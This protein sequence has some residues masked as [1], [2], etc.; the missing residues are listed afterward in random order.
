M[1]IDCLRVLHVLPTVDDA[2]GG[3]PRVV[4]AFL[5]AGA[6]LGIRSQVIA[7]ATSGDGDVARQLAASS[8]LHT[9][10]PG[11]V[12]GRLYG[13]AAMLRAVW[14]AV[15]EA[16]VVIAHSLFCLPSVFSWLICRLRRKPWVMS[17]HGC[18]DPYDVL[19]HSGLKRLLTP[20]WRGLLHGADVW[21]MTDVEAR[22]L[23][24]FGARPRVHV[25]PP[26][27]DLA[28]RL[29]LDDA[30]ALLDGGGLNLRGVVRAGGCVVSF[31][32][33]FDVKKG[34]PRLLDC[35]DRVARDND[36]LVLAGRGG[37]SYE[38]VVDGHLD[39]AE[40]R[41]QILR[42]GWLSDE[43]KV[44]LWSLPGFFALAGDNENF[45]VAVA[46]AMA[47]GM[48]V[49]VTDQV[50]LADLVTLSGA[51]LVSAPETRRFAAAM[52]VYLTDGERRRRDGERGRA[53]VQESMS[54]EACQ[55]AF[56]QMLETAISEHRPVRRLASRGA[57]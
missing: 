20:L 54:V 56:R 7:G 45:G 39:R 46:E 49:V 18:L 35:F 17:P 9:F 41:G 21:C 36:V 12:F 40:R 33:R 37:A 24:T 3:P 15:G 53:A 43:Q 31:V 1:K 42:P 52:A 32:G 48:P 27:V 57:S 13:S 11:I 55:Q 10:R 28:S 25:V 8:D 50:G 34:I 22:Q 29:P 30:L 38:R 6:A 44:A 16:D 51:G 4:A 47:A 19:K 2:Y 14:V 5:T 26:P 23:V